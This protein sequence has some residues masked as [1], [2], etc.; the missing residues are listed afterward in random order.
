MQ[1]EES[2]SQVYDFKFI[3]GFKNVYTF[4]TIN[5][6]TYEV[7]FKP[8]PYMF[9]ED[10][11][12]ANYI[13]E[14]SILVAHN[15]L[16]RQPPFDTKVPPT[17]AEIFTEFY[18][19]AP[20]NISIYICDSSDGRQQLRHLKFS[21]WF[22]HF[23]QYDFTKIDHPF[24]DSAG[25]VYPTSLIIRDDNPFRQAVAAAFLA[26]SEEYNQNK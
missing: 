23:H 8:T 25:V 22:E 13:F 16:D 3:G 26:L 24:R 18:L 19:N 6:I 14:L 4:E 7:T 12:F 20:K 11:P 17:I 5:Q 15:P 9:G 10:V 1:Q 21:R 2:L